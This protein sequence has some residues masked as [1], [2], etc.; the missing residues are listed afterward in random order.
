VQVFRTAQNICDRSLATI[1]VSLMHS[2]TCLNTLR[3]RNAE[4]TESEKVLAPLWHALRGIIDEISAAR[5]RQRSPQQKISISFIVQELPIVTD[6]LVE[7]AAKI[8]ER[9]TGFLLGGG[10]FDGIRRWKGI[11]FRRPEM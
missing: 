8:A 9:V 7:K 10:Q 2:G 11:V 5:S 3:V 6:E 1:D 4:A